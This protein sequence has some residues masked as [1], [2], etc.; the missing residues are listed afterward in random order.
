MS[1]TNVSITFEDQGNKARYVAT[2]PGVAEEA[3]LTLSK[4]SD[5]LWIADHTGVP[6]SMRGMGVGKALVEH[7]IVEMR[8]AGRQIMPLCPFVRA[9][10][11]KHPEWADVIQQR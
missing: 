4:L 9:Q 3:E 2:V 10:A 11:Q 7:L 1:D 5:A 8:A 6:D